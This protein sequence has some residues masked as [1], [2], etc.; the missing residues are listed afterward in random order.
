MKLASE[1]MVKGLRA[2]RVF[3]DL[4]R[5]DGLQFKIIWPERS[6]VKNGMKMPWSLFLN[7]AL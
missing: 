6:S 5:R 1:C 4:E 7:N 3:D 2:N